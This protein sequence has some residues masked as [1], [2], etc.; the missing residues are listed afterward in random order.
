M[1][2][3]IRF[4]PEQRWMVDN[5]H[6]RFQRDLGDGLLLFLVER[7]GGPLQ[8][9]AAD[10]CLRMPDRAWAVE[11]FA[12]GRL[13]QVSTLE[14]LTS[15]RRQA[16]QREYAPDQV[17]ELDP[18]AAL[19]RFVLEGLDRMG[20][21]VLGDRALHLALCALWAAEPDKAAQF[22]KPNPRT[23]RRWLK[24][25]G[26][27]G[28]RTSRQMLS[29]SGR[30][31]RSRRLPSVT[32][33][34]L[35]KAVLK[36]WSTPLSIADVYAWLACWV[37]RINRWRTQSP[38]TWPLLERP[39]METLRQDIRRLECYE[40]YAAKFGEKLA[41]RRF[42][43]NGKGLSAARFLQ[44]GC[45]DHSLLDQIAVID[46]E[47]MLPV[48]RPWLTV[49]ID[50]KTRCVV[51]FVLSYEPPSLFQALECIKRANQPK[52][53]LR[54]RAPKFPVLS[55]IFGR[56][57]EVVVDN[58]WEFSGK[59]FE[60]GMAD[61]GT[62]VRWAPVASPTYK[63]IVER[64][65]G[66]LNEIL[67]KKAPGGVL[68]PELLR[69]MGYDPTK[70]AVLTIAEIEDLIW[71]AITYY[72]IEEHSGI[73]RPP[74]DLWRQDMEAYG[75]DVIGD[76]HQLDRMAGAMKFPCTLSRSGVEMFGLTF[77]D[78]HA[79]GELLEDLISLQPIQGQRK[80]SATAQVKVKYNPANL[81]EVHVWNQRRNCYVTL[82]CTD[83]R[84]SAGISLWHHQQLKAWAKHKGLEFSTQED[85]L[86]ARL[87][88]VEMIQQSAPELR[89]RQRRA[90]AR[91][92]TAPK[93][94]KAL[95]GNS[96]TLA[97][98]PSR[99]DGMAPVIPHDTLARHRIDGDTPPNRP[100]R[101]SK[102][103]GRQRPEQ[104]KPKQH[105]TPKHSPADALTQKPWKGF[106]L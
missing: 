7:T 82:P 44:I 33:W 23:V 78:Q 52:L 11:A 71:E 99:Q 46:G 32:L 62:S 76:D 16:Q 21:H 81:G 100:P 34:L 38:H 75:I 27:P 102:P 73:K 51:A 42:K 88:L 14:N 40:T 45:M 56:F 61:V 4:K 53:H 63:A 31:A 90:V 13:R 43:A 55:S 106:K 97:Y 54:S 58:G 69:E 6:I 49:I 17:A 64:F 12:E 98:A 10:G 48:G 84:Y 79:T 30:V 9:R 24:E 59:S 77:H 57:D 74:A 72:H 67:N 20:V 47:Y 3:P 105:P 50:V 26:T 28:E 101:A 60:D 29:M 104:A 95:K 18:K 2:A 87:K 89:L 35:Q 80:G 25:R 5:Q 41:K 1:I 8:I 92:L 93:I 36:Y 94:L 96:A 37:E 19:R 85:R 103:K 86:A 68:K 91:L 15:A 22:G 83:E 39:S 66:T 70:D 65:F